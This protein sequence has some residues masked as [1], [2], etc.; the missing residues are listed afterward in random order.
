MGGC[1]HRVKTVRGEAEHSE[2][3]TRCFLFLVYSS[4]QSV[5]CK[6]KKSHTGK[7]IEGEL[8]D[9]FIRDVVI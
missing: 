5:I 6:C 1:N 2:R 9:I 4:E 8:S 7:V 3:G